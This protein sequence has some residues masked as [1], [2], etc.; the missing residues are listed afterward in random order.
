MFN[1]VQKTW[2]QTYLDV[3]EARRIRAEMAM[4]KVR[5][6]NAAAHKGKTAMG[7]RAILMSET[8]SIRLPLGR[9]SRAAAAFRKSNQKPIPKF[10][11]TYMRERIDAPKMPVFKKK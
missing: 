8:E 6:K 3:V 5:E 10:M 1:G 7:H 9:G 4:Q 2:R 11:Q